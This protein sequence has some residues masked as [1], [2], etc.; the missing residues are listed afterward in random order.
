MTIVVSLKK[1]EII[2]MITPHVVGIY[3]TIWMMVHNMGSE[4]M[5]QMVENITKVGNIVYFDHG[6]QEFCIT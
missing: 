5:L 1:I 4:G 2:E 3:R 6:Q